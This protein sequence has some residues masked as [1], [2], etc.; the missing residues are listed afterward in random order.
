MPLT[1]HLFFNMKK[2]ILLVAFFFTAIGFAQEK[3]SGVVTD[4]SNAPL[5]GVSVQVK[6]SSKATATDFDGKF[7]IVAKQGDV[8]K[9]TTLV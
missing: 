7:T 5:A 1:T 4:S 6:G 3:V 8:L 9:F 2:I